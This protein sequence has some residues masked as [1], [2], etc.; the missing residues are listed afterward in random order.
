MAIRG[1]SKAHI[2]GAVL[3]RRLD[4]YVFAEILGPL[5]LGFIVY[6][7]IM[8]LQFLFKSAEMIIRRGVPIGTIG[9]L[10]LLNT[11]SI[12]VLTVPMALLFGI[13]IAVG[14]LSSDS[15]LVALRASGISL[16]SLYRPILLLSALLTGLNIYLMLD[17]LPEGNH[18]LQKLRADILATSL[19]QQV[20][21]R[22]FYSGW[23]GQVLYVFEQ[24]LGEE[25][26]KGTFLASSIPSQNKED[27][28]IIAEWGDARVDAESGEVTLSLENAYT[29]RVDFTKPKAYDVILQ[30]NLDIRLETPQAQRGATAVS[31]SRRELNL[32]ELT[33][34]ATDPRQSEAE[35]NLAWVEIHK[36]FSIPAAC[37]V[38]GLLGLPLGFTNKRGGKS[39]GF[40]ISIGIILVYYVFLNWGEEIARKGTIPP[41]LA[42]WFPNAVML[43]VGLVLLT[44]RN[45]DK[46]L[47]LTRLD[48]WIRMRFWA[49][50][51]RL[52]D[53][54]EARK[55][56]RRASAITRRANPQ[57]APALVLRLPEINLAFLTR[58]DRYV[59]RTFFQVLIIAALS[60]LTIYIVAD[61]TDNVD[62]ILKNNA[63]RSVVVEYYQYKSFAIIYQIAPVIVLVS[64]LV[65]FGVLSRTNE[66]TA[67]KA[68][69]MSLFRLS[70]PVVVAA[71]L[72]AGVCG[73]LQSEVLAAANQ[74]V[75]E[76]ESIIKGRDTSLG[77]YRR[78]D[79]LWIYGKGGYAYNY[80][81]YDAER[82]EVHKLQVFKFDGQ[83]H[84]LTDRLMADRARYSGDGWWTFT[85][86]WVRSFDGTQETLYRPFD[87]PQRDRL[88]ATPEQFLGEAPLP[89]VMN[90]GELRNYLQDLED[91]GQEAPP[92]EVELH[93]KIAYPAVSLVM[94]L[95]ALPFSFRLGRR[96]ALYGIGLSLV[97]GIVFLSLV[98]FFTALGET[99]I[100]PPLVAVWGPNAIFSVFSLYLFLGV[101]S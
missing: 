23:E 80:A 57:H 94:A 18:A 53:R 24:P 47:L 93:N 58:I 92:L 16:F 2:I 32:E 88:P 59:L 82:Q 26:W 84:Q 56:A 27:D 10:L 45:R 39:S 48:Q 30:K 100:L 51:L 36:K 90:Y 79:R 38:F 89:S 81:H 46:S 21:P 87:T 70:I 49:R 96:G 37:M 5:A 33:Q 99:A 28:T 71:A 62:D 66:I 43:V 68:L 25:R 69:G 3:M 85:D 8:L 77:A 9:E 42:V 63:P 60:G 22:I 73:L 41:S 61:I 14:R 83:T 98:A 67:C 78:A 29:H 15:E 75:S 44:R 101:Q 17:V 64:T 40:A 20:E 34:R 50:L 91:I 65:T 74:R 97:L 11:P 76:L 95:V 55:R 35:R 86:G 4:R 19:A 13:L 54:R 1:F 31:R 52:Q 6:T 12:V 72:V 7:F